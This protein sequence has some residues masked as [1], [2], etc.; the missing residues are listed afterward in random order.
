MHLPKRYLRQKATREKKAIGGDLRDLLLRCFH[1]FTA[2]P[3]RRSKDPLQR[4]CWVLPRFLSSGSRC[5]HRRVHPCF[6]PTSNRILRGM[7][8]PN[9]ARV[10]S[11]G[12]APGQGRRP[13]YSQAKRPYDL[14]IRG[15]GKPW[16]Q[17]ARVMRPTG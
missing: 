3:G 17:G 16:H 14:D 11:S 15:L 13:K 7:T 9:F 2:S 10:I 5:A 4:A 8:P 12:E 6:I 1:D